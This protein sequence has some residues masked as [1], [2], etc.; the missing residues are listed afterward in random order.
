MLILKAA[1]ELAPLQLPN[2][3]GI[4]QDDRSR[5][6]QLFTWAAVVISASA[7]S[8]RFIVKATRRNFFDVCMSL[9][10]WLITLSVVCNRRLWESPDAY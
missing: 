4:T 10:D 5:E 1:Y 2:M 9:D 3:G 7:C 8:M 6:V